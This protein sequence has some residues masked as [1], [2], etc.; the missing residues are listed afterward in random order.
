M[1][2]PT[3]SVMAPAMGQPYT[4]VAGPPNCSPVPN[5]VVIPVS[6]DTI[7]NDT[8]K[9]DSSLHAKNCQ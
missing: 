9:L 5:S 7:E 6:T 8:A 3:T 4:I 2:R 1:A